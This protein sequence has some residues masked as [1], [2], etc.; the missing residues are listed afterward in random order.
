MLA[1][2]PVQYFC[3]F[4]RAAT[5]RARNAISRKL[6]ILRVRSVS[7]RDRARRRESEFF[8]P[9]SIERPKHTARVSRGDFC[10]G[11][12]RKPIKREQWIAY[13]CRA[14]YIRAAIVRRDRVPVTIR[15]VFS[16][17]Y[18]Q[19]WWAPRANFYR[20]YWSRIVFKSSTKSVNKLYRCRARVISMKS[21]KYRERERLKE[22]GT[23]F[24]EIRRFEYISREN[25]YRWSRLFG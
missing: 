22:N 19:N 8:F 14:K 4:R 25:R 15:H 6:G 3:I 16:N 13:A 10:R 21:Y 5:R 24:D 17:L 20:W 2:L 11:C 23:S 18:T 7:T 9:E 1:S 12:E